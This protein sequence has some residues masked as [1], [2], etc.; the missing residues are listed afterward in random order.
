[1]KV[2]I[3]C[4]NAIRVA[5]D[6]KK[7]TEI[8][9]YILVS[10][11]LKH[12]NNKDLSLTAFCSGDSELPVKIESIDFH[13]TSFDKTTPS[14]KH[15]IFELALISKAFFLQDTF[16]LYHANIGDGDIIL[17][18]VPFV[19]KP[20]L[21]TLH[22]TRQAAYVKRY[23]SLF[24]HLPHVFFISI[25]NA[26]R[27]FFPGLNYAGTIYNGIETDQFT[28]GRVGGES[29]MWAGRG[30]PNKGL[31]TL[32]TVLKRLKRKA[33]VF[34]LRKKEH[35]AWL[36]RQI[37]DLKRSVPSQDIFIACDKD[38]FDLINHYQ[39]SRLFLFPIGWEEPFGLVLIESMACGTPIVAFARGSV[40][41]IV[42][43]G[44]TG[45]LVNPSNAD[46]RGDWII[47]KTGIDGLC[48]AVEKIYSMP[49]EQYLRM[50]RNCR[51]LAQEQFSAERMAEEYLKVYKKLVPN[52]R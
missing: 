17:P 32:G 6:T 49:Q 51:A 7:G 9:F 50:R 18:F 47:K 13:S 3:I 22:Y 2:A 42:R 43:D 19:R 21:I 25:S 26:Q 16:D 45:F 15:I 40:P 38:R 24:S 1:M 33:K 44:E 36:Q 52:T 46:I 5:R 39:S 4:S 8:V 27:K 29:I 20:V 11:L 35:A 14:E 23:F 10:N 12:I 41:E 30:I 34:P 37:A 31:N 28:F 48:E